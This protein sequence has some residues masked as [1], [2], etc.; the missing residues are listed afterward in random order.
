MVDLAWMVD[1]IAWRLNEDSRLNKLKYLNLDQ[2]P[3]IASLSIG[4][5]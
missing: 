2:L 4:V 3:F 1:L 5:L